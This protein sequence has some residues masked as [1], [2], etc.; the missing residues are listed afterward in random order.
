MAFLPYGC[1]CVFSNYSV[2]KTPCC[3]SDRCTDPVIAGKL[4]ASSGSGGGDGAKDSM[5][6]A[7]PLRAGPTSGAFHRHP[8]GSI[9]E[10]IRR[11]ERGR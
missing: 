1:D 4:G 8:G 2:S 11:L 9:E 5:S 10:D 7:G 6:L 3:K